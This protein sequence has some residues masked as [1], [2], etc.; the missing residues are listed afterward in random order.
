VHLVTGER[1]RS[2]GWLILLDSNFDF[3]ITAM[4]DIPANVCL[5]QMI[6]LLCFALMMFHLA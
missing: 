6:S 1:N 2:N 3:V 4:S 5:L